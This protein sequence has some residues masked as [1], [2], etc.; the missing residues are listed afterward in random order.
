MPHT[1]VLVAD[2]SAARIFDAAGA[3]GPLTCVD[4]LRHPASRQT[5]REVFADS[6]GRV[7]DRMGQGRHAV[8]ARTDIHD[9]EAKR[10]AR[11][12]SERLQS[13]LAAKKFSR[14]VIMASPGFLG[15]LRA[16]LPRQLALT[17]TTE[18]PRNLT[19][20]DEAA[21]LAHMPGRD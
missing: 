16:T 6:P 12:V 13:A 4:T 7:H 2:A 19:A 11:E 3:A 14:L 10:F 8:E 15:V 20:M 1:W 21:I 9:E 5:G 17:V 18:V